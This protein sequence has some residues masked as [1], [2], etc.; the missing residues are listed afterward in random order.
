MTKIVERRRGAE[1]EAALLQA[2]WDELAAVGYARF[3]IEGVAARAGTS[4]PVLYRRWANRH[5]LAL[6]ALKAQFNSVSFDVPDMG[7]VRAELIALMTAASE[8]RVGVVVVIMQQMGEFF[9]EANTDFA[10]MRQEVLAGRRMLLEEIFERAVKRGEIDPR[11][12][13]PRVR[14]L[15]SDLMRHE[16]LMTLKP[17]PRKTIEEIIDQLFLPLVRPER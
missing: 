17:L 14:T 8:S 10:E 16:L 1:L 4:R 13:T 15:P 12:L 3:T 7:S 6:A 11:K 2:A 5:D 9:A